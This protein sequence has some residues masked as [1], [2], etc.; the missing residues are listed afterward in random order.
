M[1][2]MPS[3]IP[4][5]L[6]VPGDIQRAAAGESGG[7]RHPHQ[8]ASRRSAVH[9]NFAARR[10]Y[11]KPTLAHMRL[12]GGILPAFAEPVH[13][14]GRVQSEKDHAET[15]AMTGKSWQS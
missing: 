8:G 15:E 6:A 3:L 13:G 14:T 1:Y 12:A 11:H 5:G 4:T 7:G 10:R 2:P 9:E